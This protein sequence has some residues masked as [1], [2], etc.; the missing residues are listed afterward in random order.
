MS[1]QTNRLVGGNEKAL[2]IDAMRHQGARL[3]RAARRLSVAR[4]E[5]GIAE[6]RLSAIRAAADVFNEPRGEV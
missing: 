5:V 4:Q 6:R 3:L 1:R 2:L